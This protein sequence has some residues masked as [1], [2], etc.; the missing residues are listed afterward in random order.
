MKSFPSS[1]N[2]GNKNLIMNHA[3]KSLL[4]TVLSSFKNSFK[5]SWE[6]GIKSIKFGEILINDFELK[7]PLNLFLFNHPIIN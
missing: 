6:A 7:T 5:N 3:S 4:D 1:L 2:R